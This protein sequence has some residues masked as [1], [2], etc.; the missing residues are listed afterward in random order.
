VPH[1]A[2]RNS[3]TKTEIV[4]GESEKENLAFESENFLFF[5]G[6][7]HAQEAPGSQTP[8][9]SD[10]LSSRDADFLMETI[11]GPI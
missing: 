4:L 7:T 11:L 10:F 8:Q 9:L 2:P 6:E 3:K 5:A 1:A